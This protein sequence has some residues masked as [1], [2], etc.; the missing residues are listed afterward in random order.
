[1]D[2]ALLLKRL[3]PETV[4]VITAL[5]V[6]AADL[7]L[8]LRLPVSLRKTLAA[9]ETLVGCVIAWRLLGRPSETG[10]FYSGMWTGDP[11]IPWIK[12][13]MIALAVGTAWLSRETD[14]TRHVGEFFALLLLGTV[15]MFCMV[16]TENLLLAFVAL[17]LL[18]LSLYLMT[19]FSK[20]RPESAEAALKYFLFGGVSA[21]MLLYG[22]SLLYGATGTLQLSVMA[23]R[24]G[25]GPVEPVALLGIVLVAAGLGFKVA[26]VPFHLWAPD[27]YQAAPTPTAAFVA[28]GSKVAS[29]FLLARIMMAGL[30]GAAGSGA[31]HAFAP[32]WVPLL[33]VLAAASVVGGNL[34]ALNQTSLKR[35]L[36]YSAIAHAG[37]MLL[38]VVANRI[39]GVRA[40]LYYVVTY[41]I[42]SLGAFGAIAAVEHSTGGDSLD[43]F[44]GLSRRSPWLAWCLAVFLLSLAGI[45][46]LAGFF[47]KFYLF[48][49]ALNAKD[50][51]LGMLWLVGV[52]VAMS[53]VA[54]YYYLV[55]LKQ[56]FVVPVPEKA[57]VIR[58]RFMTRVV[59]TICVIA[60]VAWGCFPQWVLAR[61]AGV[62]GF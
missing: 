62:S 38:G 59:L 49:A 23:S 36:A 12:Q 1:V 9:L 6:L 60:I 20:D 28:S 29:F 27:T 26:A 31:Q 7:G 22:A 18:S 58:V 4:L 24:L 32:G 5:V 52:A 35:L 40:L 43:R 34:A 15:G 37:Y 41:G 13:M 16:S 45:P 54:L 51:P 61:V 55:V 53:C 44:A 48:T 17:E 56:M 39:E 42:T 2:Y 14:F 57:P 10:V 25:P 47:G 46:P 11:A 30:R 21:A 50:H 8:W 19:G 33:S 3:L